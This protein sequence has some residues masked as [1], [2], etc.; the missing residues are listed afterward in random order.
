MATAVAMKPGR[1]P[2]VLVIPISNPEYWGA[3]SKWLMKKPAIAKPCKPM[4]NMRKVRVMRAVVPKYPQSGN[5]M[6][7]AK[8]AMSNKRK[9]LILVS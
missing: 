3:M 6:I 7:P 2:I 4:A 8:L 9:A 1:F 5:R